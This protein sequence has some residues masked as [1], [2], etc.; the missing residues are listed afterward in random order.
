M[1]RCYRC[2]N[3]KGNAELNNAATETAS[4]LTACAVFTAFVNM[5]PPKG[6]NFRIIIVCGP[7]LALD[8]LLAI[9]AVGGPLEYFLDPEY[10]NSRWGVKAELIGDDGT[11]KWSG[12]RWNEGV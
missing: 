1:G 2:R 10:G 12:F 6:N 8:A 3:A 5:N 4:C 7:T 11:V 9:K